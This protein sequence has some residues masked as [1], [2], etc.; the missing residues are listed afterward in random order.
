MSWEDLRETYMTILADEGFRPEVDSDGDI[1]FK[2]E[3]GHYYITSNCDDGFFYILYPGFWGIDDE[4]EL[5]RAVMAASK[6]TRLTK[7]AKVFINSDLKDVSATAET[8]IVNPGDVQK[9]INRALR[10]I[11]SAVASFTKEMNEENEE[12]E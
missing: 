4:E 5:E 11:R 12:Q 9:L 8:L 3:G 6:A 1:H 7:A 10:C 2:Y